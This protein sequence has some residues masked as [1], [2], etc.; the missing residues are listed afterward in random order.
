MEPPRF[1][2]TSADI[3]GSVDM[4]LNT[5]PAARNPQCKEGEHRLEDDDGDNDDDD[6]GDDYMAFSTA[7]A[8]HDP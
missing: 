1:S 3:T 4:A 2:G 8:G 6:D 7:S 5:A